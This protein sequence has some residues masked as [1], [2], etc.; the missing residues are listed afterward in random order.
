[1]KT[2]KNIRNALGVRTSFNL[3]GPLLNPARA[4]HLLIGVFSS[5]YLK[6]YA[7]TVIKLGV[8]RAMIVHSCGLDELS[9]LGISHVI[10][11]RHGKKEEKYLDPK[12]FG[13]Q[14]CALETI[15]GGAAEKNKALIEAALTG[16][17]GP[18]AD[19]IVL[20]TGAALYIADN[21]ITLEDGIALAAEKIKTGDA[22]KVLG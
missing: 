1:M 13:F 7:D 3:L 19:T 9:L 22:L 20:N 6:I 21:V 12:D 11:I 10:E 18:I 15:Q 14:Y 16:T 2:I 17:P 5:D 8:K 4:S